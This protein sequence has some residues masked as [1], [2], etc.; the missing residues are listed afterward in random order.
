M[1]EVVISPC[2]ADQDTK[3]IIHDKKKIVQVLVQSF[4]IKDYSPKHKIK[5]ELNILFQDKSFL[6]GVKGNSPYS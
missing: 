6:M 3:W 5:N 4:S 2:R 1:C